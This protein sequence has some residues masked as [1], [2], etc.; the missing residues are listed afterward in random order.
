MPKP[1]EPIHR[2]VAKAIRKPF[3]DFMFG[4]KWE[5][6]LEQLRLNRKQ[7]EMPL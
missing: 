1:R 7:K 5:E 3:N 6:E 2:R 4:P